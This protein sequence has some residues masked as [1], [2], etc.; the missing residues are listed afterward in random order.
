MAV[1]I[2]EIFLGET[3]FLQAKKDNDNVQLWTL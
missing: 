1:E 3:G 2:E